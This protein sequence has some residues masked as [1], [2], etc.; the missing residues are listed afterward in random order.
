MKKVSFATLKGGTGKTMSLFSVAGVLAEKKNV[1]MVDCDPQCNLTANSGIDS[2]DTSLPS[3]KDVFEDDSVT[4][5]QVIVKSPIKE[6]PKLDIIPSSM[7]LFETE[8]TLAS[9]TGRELVLKNWFGQNEEYFSRYDYILFDTNPSMGAIN[10]NA[11]VLADSIVLVTDVGFNSI[12]GVEMFIYLWGK[13]R[14]GL[15]LDDNVKALIVNNSDKRLNLAGELV[16]YISTQEALEGL[17]VL[18]AIPSRAAIKETEFSTKPITL[19]K[20]TSD[21]ADTVRELVKNLKKKG[22]L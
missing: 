5:E 4:P 13:N 2:A 19:A 21:A 7:Y 6:A 3:L 16:E 9:R 14:K 17:L 10:V 20:P 12:T 22:A 8:L 1:L 18:P 15:A 11:F